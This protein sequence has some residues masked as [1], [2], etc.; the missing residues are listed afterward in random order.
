MNESE[1]NRL[2]ISNVKS[3]CYYQALKILGM[4]IYILIWSTP[5]SMPSQLSRELISDLLNDLFG[6]S[7][8]LN[9]SGY[10]DKNYSYNFDMKKQNLIDRGL[11]KHVF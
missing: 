5:C 1:Y 11:Y 2:D 8:A 10:L 4:N 9:V 6:S 7:S 3:L